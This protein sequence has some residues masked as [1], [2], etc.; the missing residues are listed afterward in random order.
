MKDL[1]E[2]V[3]R[4]LVDDEASVSV[5]EMRTERMAVYEITVADDDYGKLIGTQGAH[6]KALRILLSSVARKYG[7]SAALEVNDPKHRKPKQAEKP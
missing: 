5:K 6:V 3:A 4:H 2:M 1:I 7:L